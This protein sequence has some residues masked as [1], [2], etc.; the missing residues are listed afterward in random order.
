MRNVAKIS[1]RFET[2]PALQHLSSCHTLLVLV[3]P[4]GAAGDDQ[5][6]SEIELAER[7]GKRVI[8]AMITWRGAEK[9]VDE[10]LRELGFDPLETKAVSLPR[11]GPTKLKV[12]DLRQFLRTSL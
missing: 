5:M 2:G 1:D 7:F 8:V 9:K 6:I 10:R 12:D 3:E 11:L 4:R